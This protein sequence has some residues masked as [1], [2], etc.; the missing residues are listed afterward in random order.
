ML[1]MRRRTFPPTFAK[2]FVLEIWICMLHVDKSDSIHGIFPKKFLQ[3]HLLSLSLSQND[4]FS[5]QEV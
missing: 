2:I 5:W 3:V 1:L 4:A